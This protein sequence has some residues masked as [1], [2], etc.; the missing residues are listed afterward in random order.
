M[1]V[2]IIFFAV[3]FVLGVCGLV[4]AQDVDR[5]VQQMMQDELRRHDLFSGSADNGGYVFG[6]GGE[7]SNDGEDNTGRKSS[8]KAFGLSLLVPGMGQYYTG[9][10]RTARYYWAAE[11][12]SWLAWFGFRTYGD[13]R[14]DDYIRFAAEHAGA[15]LKGKPDWLV[16]MVGYYDDLNQYNELGRAIARERPYLAP[17]S[18]N[19]WQWRS[20]YDKLAFRQ[21][22][23]GSREAYRRADFML[24]M[25]I[26]NRLVSAIH[27]VHLAKQTGKRLDDLADAD[28]GGGL[29]YRVE[30]DPFADGVQLGLTLFRRF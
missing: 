6:A 5:S 10:V 19:D 16:D 9:N 22:K 23:N 13:W 2:R 15:D 21:I 18:G 24:G 14:E 1:K 17:S 4:T 3:L 20:I 8:T 30:A 27:A 28:S 25:M 26:I 7:K 12:L 29:Q 11:G